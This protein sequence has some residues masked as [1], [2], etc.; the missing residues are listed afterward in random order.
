M[1][2]TARG[3][4][5]FFSM[6]EENPV[7][8][9]HIR[10]KGKAVL[11]RQSRYGEMIT[12][13]ENRRETSLVLASQI[14]ATFEGRARVNIANALA[15][16]AAAVADDIQL[17]HIRQ[18]LRTFSSSFF[19]TPGRFNLL[20]VGGQRVVMDYCHNVAGLEAIADFVS[21]MEANR[22]VAVISMP[23]DRSDED[24]QAF[25]EL[26]AKTFDRI[27]IREDDNRRGR[28]VGEIAERL[29]K[30]AVDGGM[31]ED[32]MEVVLDEMEA[33]RLAIDTT[34][35]EELVVL[36]VDKPQKV[37][38]MLTSRGAASA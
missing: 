8:Q 14:P 32:T 19:Q 21:R 7:I 11:L 29:R 22:T 20:D 16:T 26:A 18:A 1:A 33:C 36:L 23:G 37:W 5:I 35:R 3:E 17:D 34:D 4:I 31:P 10:E 24:M 15:A 13:V 12:V 28:D 25:G 9:E 6:D 2:Q 30:G 27:I 38:T